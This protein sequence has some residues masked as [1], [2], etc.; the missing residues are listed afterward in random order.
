MGSKAST[1]EL[2]ED[3]AEVNDNWRGIQDGLSNTPKQQSPTNYQEME[4][5][6]QERAHAYQRKREHRQ[7]RLKKISRE[8]TANQMA[9][10]RLDSPQSV[11]DQRRS[12][13]RST[14]TSQLSNHVVSPSLDDYESTGKQCDPGVEQSFLCCTCW[15]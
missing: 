13:W 8:W 15:P 9:N 4:Q 12:S 5:R 10:S 1:N 6:E 2:E 11:P 3:C 14:S 7:A